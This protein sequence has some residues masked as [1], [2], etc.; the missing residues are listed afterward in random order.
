MLPAG[1]PMSTGLELRQLECV[2]GRRSLFK[3]LNLQVRPGQLLRLKGANGAGKTSLLRMICGLLAPASG[4]VLWRGQRVS[5]LR[6]EFGR[7]LIYLGHAAA[8]KDDL[9]ALENLQTTCLLAGCATS[10]PQAAAALGEAGLRGRERAP[11]RVLSQGQRKRVALARL[12]LGHDAPLWVLDEPFNA[13]DVAATDW[14]I[15]LI[16]TQVQRGGI[17]VL[18]S[19]QSVVFD[20]VLPQVALAL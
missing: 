5:V 12:V 13:L 15:G 3:G 17:V 8:L 9:S 2:R 16:G 10:L 14:L 6:E 19:H 1:V 7:E 18:T 20:D 11:A 4:D